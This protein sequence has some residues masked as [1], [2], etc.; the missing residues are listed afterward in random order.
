MPITW[1]HLLPTARYLLPTA[2]LL[3]TGCG[4]CRSQGA[5]SGDGG[6]AGPDAE[7]D[8]GPPI[9]DGVR[10]GLMGTEFRV[11]IAGE[12]PARAREAIEAALDEV[13]RIERALSPYRDD[14]EV[15]RINRAAALE[16]VR[17]SP[18]TLDLLE[19]ARE[20]SELSG[21]AF[22]VTFAALSPIWRSL[23]EDPPRLPADE[24]I[25]EARGLVDWRR[26]EL[27]REAGTAF[28]PRRG[29]RIDL[30]GIGKGHA[31]DRAGEVLTKRGIENFIVGGGGD[32]LVRGRKL[33]GPW[34]LGIQHPRRRG[35]LMGELDLPEGGA[36]VTS[37]D[38]ERFVEIDGTRYHHI[39]DPRT[40]RPVR[41][42]TAVTLTAPNAT[43][44]DA[45]ST[46]VFVLGPE[47]GLA[48]VERTEGVEAILVDGEMNVTISSGLRDR[49]QLYESR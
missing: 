42:T 22:D 18:E 8:A 25:D 41:G 10:D 28:L 29:M 46:A 2:L 30:G 13:A 39:I 3:M 47:A 5:S 11:S 15:S 12:E 36:L 24:A 26:L 37:G 20:V 6:A 16:P 17:V 14:S 49:V 45:L 9:V 33:S 34:R 48:L 35:E 23:R 19:R 21:G 31:V 4:D 32:L 43:L 7:P 1:N 27:D 38:Y 44:A 40:G